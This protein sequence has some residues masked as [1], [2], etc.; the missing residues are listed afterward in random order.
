MLVREDV[1]N[2]KCSYVTTKVDALAAYLPVIG[3]RTIVR[4]VDLTRSG[5]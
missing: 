2:V 1:A 4:R 3:M 5:I